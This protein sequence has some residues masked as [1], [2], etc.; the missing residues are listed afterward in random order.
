MNIIFSSAQSADETHSFPRPLMCNHRSRNWGGP[1]GARPPQYINQGGPGPPNV[2]AI[3]GTLTVKM[4]FFDP[5]S[6]HF[7]NNFLGLST[8]FNFKNVYCVLYTICT[9][10]YM[11]LKIFGPPN[12][13]HLPT[14]LA[15]M[16]DFMLLLA[17]PL[18]IWHTP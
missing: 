15:T 12:I 7:C 9:H 2:G 5:H 6:S 10:M 18:P 1:G 4:D 16:I 13:K 8:N 17:F 11:S 3:K 14:P